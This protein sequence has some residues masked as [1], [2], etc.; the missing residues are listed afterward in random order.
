MSSFTRRMATA[1]PVAQDYGWKGFREV[2]P[3]KIP[4]RR[5]IAAPL[6]YALLIPSICPK[7]LAHGRP[8]VLVNAI[9]AGTSD[10]LLC[11]VLLR[12]LRERGQ[13]AVWITSR[14]PGLFRHNDNVQA[15][16]APHDRCDFLLRRLGTKVVYPLYA[17]YH[18]A[19]DREDPI[20]EQHII[21][22][23]CQK[24]G[25]CGPINLKP[26]LT[27]TI[28]ELMAGRLA[29]RQIAIQSS[30]LAAHPPMMNRNWPD[31]GY[32]GVVDDLKGEFTIVQLGAPTDPP[33][34]GAV[35]LRGKTNLRETAAVLA[36]SMA[37]VGQVG[38]LMH[39]ARAV[40]CRSVI[41]YGGRETPAQSGY[42]CNENLYSAVPCSPCWKL[43]ACPY[44]RLCLALISTADVL[45]SIRIQIPKFRSPLEID[46]LTITQDQIERS[47]ARYEAAVLAHQAAW[48]ALYQ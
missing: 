12:E 26:T 42:S 41:I 19:F 20:P 11:T 2:L 31:S 36:S 34:A 33:L 17:S 47:A 10:D 24:A 7:L 30:G 13:R 35:D 4:W 8:Q 37:F 48:R 1:R 25:I 14:N 46:Q 27:L 32:Q 16:V 6:D 44:D 9:G 39:M 3:E 38:L 22:V 5:I 23:M 40:D 43:N 28:G 15:V 45:R 18:P 29:T 21:A